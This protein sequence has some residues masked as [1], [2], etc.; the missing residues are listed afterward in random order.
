MLINLFICAALFLVCINLCLLFAAVI[1][2]K[3]HRDEPLESQIP[4]L[5][6]RL[7]LFTVNSI[8][9]AVFQII[10]IVIR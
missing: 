7:T 1:H 10:I 2:L 9:T 4:Y 3:K 8:L 5:S 6:P